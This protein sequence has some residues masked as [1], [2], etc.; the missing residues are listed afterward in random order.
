MLAQLH[1]VTHAKTH[2]W[3]EMLEK[4]GERQLL[5]PLLALVRLVLT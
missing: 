5:L 2:M 3:T 1:S 4:C